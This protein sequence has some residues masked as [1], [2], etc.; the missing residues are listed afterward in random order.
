MNLDQ[1]PH[2]AWHAGADGRDQH[3][4]IQDYWQTL[5]TRAAPQP[6]DPQAY[7]EVYANLAVAW[8]PDT[9]EVDHGL[10]TLHGDLRGFAVTTDEYLFRDRLVS[11]LT[12]GQ[13]Q[14]LLGVR[15]QTQHHPK[16]AAP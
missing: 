16:G 13:V 10:L 9:G 4:R 5:H 3:L 15:F 6:D 11:R 12:P 2:P 8:H 7:T 14:A 1:I